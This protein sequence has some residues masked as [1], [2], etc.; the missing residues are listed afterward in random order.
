MLLKIEKEGYNVKKYLSLKG[1]SRREITRIAK[2]IKIN[3]EKAYLT[4]TLKINDTLS[5]NLQG[6]DEGKNLEKIEIKYQNNDLIIVNKPAGIVAH[7]DRI[8][9]QDNLTTKLEKQ[10]N[11]KVYPIL[12]LDKNVSGLM[13]FALNKQTA[14]YLNKLRQENKLNKTYLAIIEGKLEKEEGII[15]IRSKKKQ[16]KYIVAEEGKKCLTE[17]KFIKG[18]NNYSLYKVHILTGRS[19]QIR[20][21]FAYLNH[22]L[23]GDVLYGSKTKINR[24]ALH[25]SS[26]IFDDIEITEELPQ[27]IKELINE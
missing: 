18:N 9:E 16:K 27:Q 20:L 4:S 22:P 10:I 5:F 13:L 15:E 23:L 19:H 2:T 6:K 25:A 17:Y 8:H 26:I 24:I 7:C 3:D 21:S 11:H 1:Y 14:A 12:R